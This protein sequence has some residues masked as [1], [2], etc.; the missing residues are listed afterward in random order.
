MFLPFFAALRAHR[1]PVSLRE[2]LSFLDGMAA[3]LVYLALAWA[4]G[5]GPLRDLRRPKS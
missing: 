4:L 1:V 2:Y 3:G 5:V